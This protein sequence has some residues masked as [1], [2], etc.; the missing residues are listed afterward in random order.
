MSDTVAQHA[1]K[2]KSKKKGYH[3]GRAYVERGIFRNFTHY[4][5]VHLHDAKGTQVIGWYVH[6]VPTREEI[7]H[8]I[9]EYLYGESSQSPTDRA[10]G[11]IPFSPVERS[12]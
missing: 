7:E 5:R 8:G 6:E 1:V 4:V 11:S 12:E 10:T 9:F 2:V 3:V